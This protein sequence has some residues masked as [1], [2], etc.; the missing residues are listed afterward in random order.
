M[1]SDKHILCIDTTLNGC[2]VAVKPA[3]QDASFHVEIMGRGQSDRLIPMILECVDTRGLALQD[4]TLICTSTGPGSFT[5]TRIGLSAAQGLALSLDVETVGYNDFVCVVAANGFDKP[6]AIAID[7]KRGDF[8]FKIY[9]PDN[10]FSEGSI[11]E[12]D[13]VLAQS[14][15]MFLISNGDIEGVEPFDSE[16]ILRGLLANALETEKGFAPSA[17]KPVYMREAE[18]SVSKIKYKTISSS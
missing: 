1:T 18:T 11:L 6:C 16:T 4:I 14:K 8:F 10:G 15:N 2:S 12:A 7:T 3:N 17:L 13:D 5:G 9:H